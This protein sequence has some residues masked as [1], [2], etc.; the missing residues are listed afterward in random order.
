MRPQSV[1]RRGPRSAAPRGRSE[2]SPGSP[3]RKP[4]SP[5]LLATACSPGK[6][7]SGASTSDSAASSK[8]THASGHARRPPE[9]QRR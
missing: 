8:K 5:R 6:P 9:S 7:S 4:R 3:R 2:G 1:R